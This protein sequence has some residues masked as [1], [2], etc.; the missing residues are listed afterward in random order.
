LK[1]FENQKQFLKP[2]KLDELAQYFGTNRST[3][4]ALLNKVKGNFNSYI[5]ELRIVE[6]LKDLTENSELRKLNIQEIA[7]NYG[8]ANPK[9]FTQQFKAQT[10]LTTSYFIEQL[11]LTEL[12]YKFG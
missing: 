1:R 7:E 5:N 12:D 3:L 9:S 10:G 11:E 8:F 6:V 2:L 4:S